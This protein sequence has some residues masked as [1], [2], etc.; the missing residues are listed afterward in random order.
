MH[1]LERRE[2]VFDLRGVRCPII[3]VTD[4]WQDF[5]L[6]EGAIL[7][8]L[9]D[10][11]VPILRQCRTN[12]HC[13]S[14]TIPFLSICRNQLEEA[15]IQVIVPNRIITMIVGQRGRSFFRMEL[16][17]F[18]L[19]L[20]ILQTSRTGQPLASRAKQAFTLSSIFTRI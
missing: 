2:P 10:Q 12:P 6:T 14:D 13:G 11:A 1:K 16:T 20:R 17:V 15:P 3:Q 4:W 18:E 7:T 8:S 9:A 5:P 19:I